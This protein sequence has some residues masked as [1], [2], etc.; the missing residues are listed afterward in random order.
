M[1]M[2]D[3]ALVL[4][5]LSQGCALGTLTHLVI[6][7][8]NLCSHAMIWSTYINA[9]IVST[10]ILLASVDSGVYELCPP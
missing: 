2:V 4:F 7:Y 8:L 9:G 10:H 3:G 1:T 5:D 6:S